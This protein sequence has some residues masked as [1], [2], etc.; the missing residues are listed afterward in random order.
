MLI[1]G[2]GSSGPAKFD[3]A[4]LKKS[5]P[6]KS[7]NAY[8]GCVSAAAANILWPSNGWS[9]KIVEICRKVSAPSAE[10]ASALGIL[11]DAVVTDDATLAMV[12]G[13]R[14]VCEPDRG[15]GTPYVKAS[16]SWGFD[17]LAK[18]LATEQDFWESPDGEELK[19]ESATRQRQRIAFQRKWM[20]ELRKC[21]GIADASA[22]Y[23][24]LT[25]ET[26]LE[27]GGRGTGDLTGYLCTYMVEEIANR[28]A[29]HNQP[30]FV[31]AASGF[32]PARPTDKTNNNFVTSK[33]QEI[34]G[35][36]AKWCNMELRK[37]GLAE[38]TP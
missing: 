25:A 34:M 12:N 15:S 8:A 6:G 18:R 11:A 13:S 1:A 5:E 36:N 38:L 4:D 9:D 19:N 30:G 26:D 21:Y 27:D 24:I 7:Y 14:D 17:A 29:L 37:S 16:P 22:C 2:C 35:N 31:V 3:L 10:C 20:T 32:V 33:S 28:Q 23:A